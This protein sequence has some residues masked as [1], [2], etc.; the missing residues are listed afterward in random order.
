MHAFRKR[1][2]AL[3][4][5]AAL[6]SG[7]VAC[8]KKGSADL[9]DAPLRWSVE[10]TDREADELY[11]AALFADGQT[12]LYLPKQPGVLPEVRDLKSGAARK[13]RLSD[14]RI[15]DAEKA[16]R[17]MVVRG[18]R[19]YAQM[20]TDALA[21][22]LKTKHGLEILLAS[23]YPITLR[24]QTYCLTAAKSDLL[25]VQDSVTGFGGMID[26]K[27]GTL[28]CSIPGSKDAFVPMSASGTKILGVGGRMTAAVLDTDDLSLE[29]FDAAE[30]L[31]YTK[32][33]GDEWYCALDSLAYLADGSIAAI[34]A[35]TAF[36]GSDRFETRT[37]GI[38][39]K[40]G[41]TELYDL[42]D[43]IASSGFRIVSS[44][45]DYVIAEPMSFGLAAPRLVNRKT[46]EVRALKVEGVGITA[47]PLAEAK[48]QRGYDGTFYT[49]DVLRDGRSLLVRDG[50]TGTF[51]IFDPAA[52]KTNLITD[53]DEA[54]LFCM[55]FSG[56]HRGNLCAQ[57]NP[58]DRQPERGVMISIT[59]KNGDPILP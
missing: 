18:A 28:Y 48:D 12:A 38:M 23:P 2:L 5:I 3:L 35:E 47:V 16:L 17:E 29:T 53:E 45:P 9:Y 13:V 43:D 40:D 55:Y 32:K 19:Q 11:R 46:G 50:G 42:G 52:L 6:L 33:G 21:E 8:A 34:I 56:D 54:T 26:P 22:Q 59:D 58:R 57:N 14:F 4:L 24:V 7:G 27:T 25:C 1:I 20:D 39:R 36:I 44:D 41:G 49:V 15:E 51:A 30:A 10:R 37:L 31:G